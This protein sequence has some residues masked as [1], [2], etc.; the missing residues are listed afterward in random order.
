MHAS[1]TRTCLLILGLSAVAISG[2]TRL[3]ARRL[4]RP[5]GQEPP[6]PTAEQTSLGTALPE[7][8]PE[9]LVTAEESNTRAIPPSQPAPE[10]SAEVESVFNEL[11]SALLALESLLGSTVTWDLNLP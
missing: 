9:P 10:H 3:D 2:C 8:D 7:A 4:E 1:R 5:L 11:D 6:S